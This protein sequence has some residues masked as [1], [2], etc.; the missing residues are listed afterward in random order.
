MTEDRF[1]DFEIRLRKVEDFILG[2]LSM[3]L[4]L[5]QSI[6]GRV[7]VLEEHDIEFMAMVHSSCTLKDKEIAKAKEDAIEIAIDYVDQVHKQTW[8]GI[9]M[10][11]SLFIGAVVYF[12]MQVT[13]RAIASQKNTTNIENISKVLDKIDSKLDKLA[14]HSHTV[15]D[16]K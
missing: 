14:D 2:Q 7:E 15:K 10:M 8:V 4:E 16:T 5:S 6:K 11:F 12:N 13:D 9:A 3:L 1:R